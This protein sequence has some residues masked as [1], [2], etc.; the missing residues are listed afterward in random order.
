MGHVREKDFVFED[1]DG[2]DFVLC[3]NAKE[4]DQMLTCS[5]KYACLAYDVLIQGLLK[6]LE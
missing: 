1:L 3:F 4:A 6:V 2:I 5:M